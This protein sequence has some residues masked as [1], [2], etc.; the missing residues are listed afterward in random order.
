MIP[1]SW[2]YA[3][4]GVACVFIFVSARFAVLA[5]NERNYKERNQLIR[6]TVIFG[7]LSFLISSVTAAMFVANQIHKTH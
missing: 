1:I 4:F 5:K 6:R 7:L 2:V 3:S